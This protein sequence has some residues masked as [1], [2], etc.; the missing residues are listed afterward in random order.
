MEYDNDTARKKRDQLLAAIQAGSISSAFPEDARRTILDSFVEISPPQQEQLTIGLILIDPTSG[1]PKG[2]SLK[3]GNVLLNWRK[4]FEVVPDV[5]LA[6]LGAPTL[7]IP[8]QVAIV[9]AALYVSNKLVRG[10]SEELSEA[11]AVT[12]LALWKGRN[13]RDQISD[14]DGFKQTN[15]ERRGYGLPPLS[16]RQY[17]AAVDQLVVLGCIELNEGVI[18]LVEAIRVTYR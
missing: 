1:P 4:L 16:Y 3:P 11:E 6:S 13:A 5:S 12:I 15:L 9:L 2:K 14:E 8:L 10:A 17:S 18:S 7:P